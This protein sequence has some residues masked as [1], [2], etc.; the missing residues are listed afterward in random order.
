[1][2]VKFNPHSKTLFLPSSGFRIAPT[3][4][5]LSKLFAATTVGASLRHVSQLGAQN[6]KRTSWPNLFPFCE[7]LSVDSSPSS[8]SSRPSTVSPSVVTA[9]KSSSGG[10]TISTMV[11]VVSTRGTVVE[12]E[13]DLAEVIESFG[14]GFEQ[15]KITRDRPNVKQKPRTE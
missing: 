13:E 4:T 14:I 6:Q 11:V 15:P 7:R 8:Q 9:M 5:T 3:P 10:T 12:E 2:L 1:M